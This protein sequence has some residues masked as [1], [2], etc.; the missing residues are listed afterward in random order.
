MSRE[1]TVVWGWVK[2]FMNYYYLFNFSINKI[3][4]VVFNML[5]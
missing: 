4:V 1:Y 2:K 3:L 5:K